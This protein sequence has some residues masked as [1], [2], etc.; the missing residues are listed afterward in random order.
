LDI[1]YVLAT[2]SF[3]LLNI[4]RLM[5]PL[6]KRRGIAYELDTMLDFAYRELASWDANI[7]LGLV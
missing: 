5:V 2:Q 1:D 3:R 6:D 7:Q 4:V